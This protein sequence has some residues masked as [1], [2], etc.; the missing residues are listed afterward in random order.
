MGTILLIILLIVIIAGLVSIYFIITYNNYQEYIIRINEVEGY[1][2]NCIRDKFDSLSKSI[3]IIKGNTDIKDD[4]FPEIIKL[5]SR[6]LS[7]FELDRKLVE[8]LNEFY[9]IKEE[10][11]ELMKSTAFLEI[12][13]KL[14]EIEENLE[15]Y[16]EYYNENITK[17]NKLVRTFPSNIVGIMFKFKVKNF[18]DGKDMNDED[19][20]DFKL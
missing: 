11:E 2:D 20:N 19:V 13:I 10:H 7:S 9:R 1:I 6:K 4:L 14:N 12:D 16:K 3:S 17:Y 18:F 15:S 8:P 5:R